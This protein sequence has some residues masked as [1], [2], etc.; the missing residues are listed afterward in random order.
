MPPQTQTGAFVRGLGLFVSVPG[1]VL[2]A[3]ALGFGAL[4]RDGGFQFEHALFLSALVFALPNQL[5]LIDQL[6]RGATLASAALAVTLTAV[7]LMPMTITLVPLILGSKRGRLLEMLAVHFVAISTWIEGQRRLPAMPEHVRLPFHLGFGTAMSAM[8]IGGTVAGYLLVAGV[9]AFVTATLLFI[10]PLY[11]LLSLVATS[12]SRMD[13]AAVGLG[14]TLSPVLY[15]VL[16][17]F[18]LLVTGLA[19]GTLAYLVGRRG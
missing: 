12:R 16:P 18:D 1:I 4:A 10:T 2:F 14:C 7:R 6:M 13:L 8:M 17:G 15:V 5:V 11:F 9:P 19:G 3:T